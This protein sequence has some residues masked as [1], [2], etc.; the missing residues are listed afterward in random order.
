MITVVAVVLAASCATLSAA[1][2]LVETRRPRAFP[3]RAAAA[4]AAGS[5]A[6]AI[7]FLLVLG[8]PGPDRWLTAGARGF[9]VVALAFGAVGVAGIVRSVLP[10]GG[11]GPAVAEGLLI[12]SAGVTALWAVLG[13]PTGPPARQLVPVLVAVGVAALLA[14]VLRLPVAARGRVVDDRYHGRVR[15][16][17]VALFLMLVACLL[18]ALPARVPVV[19]AGLA[20]AAGFLVAALVP[21]VRDTPPLLRRRPT[22]GVLLLPY[23]VLAVAMTAV[24]VQAARGRAG[25]VTGVLVLLVAGVVVVVEAFA[26]RAGAV[27]LSDLEVSRQRLEALV[28]NA[29]DVILGLDPGG[30]VVAANAAVER[31]LG[32]PGAHLEGRDVAEIAVL[33]DRPA[34]RQAVR[35]VVHGR[36]PSAKV[37]L[38]LAAPAE[39]TAEMRLRGVEGG[40][41]A[42]VSDVTDAVLLRERLQLL[43]RH[44]LMTGLVNRAVVLDTVRAWLDTGDPVSVLYC[45]LDGYKAVNDRFGHLAGDQVLVEV[46][47]RLGTAVRGIVADDAVLGRIGG[48][49]FVIALR[50]VAGRDALAAGDRLVAAMRSNFVVGDRTV[51]LG[52]SVGVSGTDDAEPLPLGP[53]RGAGR[54]GTGDRPRPAGERA[55][56]RAGER[57]HD[58]TGRRADHRVEPVEGQGDDWLDGFEELLDRERVEPVDEAS[59]VGGAASAAAEL[60]HRGD[61]AMFEAKA[62]G[63]AKVARWGPDVSER[64]LR[65][66]D[67]AIGLRQ[68][69]DTGRLALA[70]QPLVRLSDGEVVGV[71]ALIRFDGGGDDAPGALSRLPGFVSPA[72]LVEVAEDTGEITEMGQWVLRQATQR[73]SLWRALGHDL[74]VAVNMS[75]RQMSENGFVG[76][77]RRAL[78]DSELAA[79]KLVVEITEGQLVGE[80]DPVRGVIEDLQ[81]DGVQFV[82][83]DFGTGYSSLS[84]LKTMPVRAIKLDRTL[85]DGIGTDPRATTLAR[86]VVG[87]AR[88]LGLVVVAEG[89][90]S[91]DAARL[92]RDLG[93]WAGQGFALHPP[94]REDELLAVLSSTPL[95]LG[96]RSG[97]VRPRV[98][99][100]TDATT[101][102]LGGTPAAASPRLSRSWSVPAGPASRAAPS[103]SASG[104]AASAGTASGEEAADRTG[105]EPGP[106]ASG[107]APAGTTSG[108]ATGPLA[109]GGFRAHGPV[110]EAPRHTGGSGGVGGVVLPPRRVSD[111]ETGTQ[112]D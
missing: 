105:P 54:P 46:A 78:A 76:T 80:E 101:A 100:V 2:W 16:S 107:D 34:V 43:A 1:S 106:T 77:V 103:R 58:R 49:E 20:A 42:V 36:R 17:A 7:A 69:L 37:E 33:D 109:T 64:A 67:I 55:H 84:Y 59:E 111:G 31:L 25:L 23:A 79:D 47:R 21:Y 57:A 90:E 4:V 86:S 110:G 97:P 39:G 68:A 82:I 92:V 30:R 5:A 74:F 10:R 85:L 52:I 26:L 24:G 50:G 56:D 22:F 15:V 38:R 3:A 63:R 75:V 102:A 9:L 112:G 65:R 95:D 72:E 108:P 6:A 48:D 62:A 91:L 28:E 8:R 61:L 94:L 27:V 89:L 29:Q 73:A 81:R 51:R 35:D 53:A 70:Y 71:E 19:A 45:D 41:V 13:A 96:A 88:A 66:V 104:G 60:L 32:L 83:D 87:V 98:V 12:G 99:D 18:D 93:A 11:V 40:A 14:T 44:D